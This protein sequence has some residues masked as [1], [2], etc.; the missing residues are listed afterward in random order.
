MPKYIGINK[1]YCEAIKYSLISFCDA[2]AKAYSAA[3][4]LQQSSPDSCK[5][6]LIFCKTRLALQNTTI[7]RLELLGVWIGVRALKFVMKELRVQVAHIFVFTD[8]LCVLHW[9]LIKNHCRYLSLID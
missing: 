7:P 9:L 8:S 3:A 2:S 1:T 5:T 6:D 4:Y